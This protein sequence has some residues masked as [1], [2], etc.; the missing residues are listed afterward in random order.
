MSDRLTSAIE[1]I[2]AWLDAY[3]Q[4]WHIPGVAI[5]VTDQRELLFHREY[6]HANLD[7]GEP[8]SP[9]HLFQ[10]GSIGK[11]FTSIA[12]LQLAEEGKLDLDDEVSAHLPWFAVSTHYEPIRIWHLLSHTAGIIRGSEGSPSAVSQVATLRQTETGFPPGSRFHYSNDGYKVLGLIAAV[13]RGLGYGSVIRQHILDPLG[14]AMTEPVITHDVHS[15]MAVGYAPLFDDRP[16]RPGA[17]L[18]P[19]TWFE[20]DTGDGSSSSNA[21][22]LATFARMLLN[23][24]QGDH[25]RIISEASFERMSSSVIHAPDSRPDAHYGFGLRTARIG[26]HLCVYHGGG[27]PGYYAFMLCDPE[28][29]LAV[30]VLINGAG[31]PG[32]IAGHCLATARAVSEKRPLPDPPTGL[33]ADRESFAQF[34]GSYVGL[35]GDRIAIAVDGGS[36]NFSSATVG[37][38]LIP[39]EPDAFY[40]DHPDLERVRLRFHRENGAVSGA[41]HGGTW[42]TRAGHTPRVAR[43]HPA[44]WEGYAGHYRAWTPWGTNFRILLRNGRLYIDDPLEGEEPLHPLGEGIFRVGADEWSPERIRFVTEIDGVALHANLSGC[45]YHRV[46]SG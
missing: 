19:A 18:I 36:L 3:R 24:G 39:L 35:S 8:V 46:F 28:A 11:T 27:M 17:P 29:G 9:E 2:D 1:H 5:A 23:R 43:E 25:A 44:E 37:A 20:G 10:F 15:R 21:S 31:D 16:Y 14:L 45:V 30:T 38:A 41:S 33:S 7:A 4:A 6:G 12:I 13:R 34:E 40:V 42:W 32:V 26:G 22:D